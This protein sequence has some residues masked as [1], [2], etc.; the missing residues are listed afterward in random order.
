MRACGNARAK[1]P[2]PHHPGDLDVREV[3]DRARH[4]LDRVQLG[5]AR[6]DDAER[7]T[8]RAALAVRGPAGLGQRGH[9][10]ISSRG[11]HA[12]GR[13]L[14]GAD[15]LDVA[16]A[17]AEVALEARADLRVGG[18][19][20]RLEQARRGH[21][22][23]RGA[24]PALRATLLEE[25]LLDRMERRGARARLDVPS[26]REALDRGDLASL[27]VERQD[28]ARR[29]GPPVH[30]DRAGAAVPRVAGEVGPGEPEVAAKEL[31]ERPGSGHLAAHPAP[32]HRQ[33][34]RVTLVHAHQAPAE[35]P[36]NARRT[37]APTISRRYSAV[38]RTSPIGRAAAVASSATRSTV[39]GT[40]PPATSA[41]SA[42]ATR[43]GVGATAPRASRASVT[44][45]SVAAEREGDADDGDVHGAPHVQALVADVPARVLARNL[46]PREQLARRERGA[47]GTPEEL[48]EGQPPRAGRADDADL[49]I[50]D[51]QHRREIRRGRGVA[52]VAADRGEVSDRGRAHVA[53]GERQHRVLADDDGCSMSA[54]SVVSAPKRIAVGRHVDGAQSGN[55]LQVDHRRRA[56]L[57]L[58]LTEMDHEIRA[59]GQDRRAR[60][61]GQQAAR[62]VE[63]GRTVMRERG[64][65]ASSSAARRGQSSTLHSPGPTARPNRHTTTRRRRS[66][67]IR[68]VGYPSSSRKTGSVCAPSA[69][70]GRGRKGGMP[71]ALMGVPSVGSV[72]SRGCSRSTTISRS[73]TCGSFTDLVHR[74]DRRRRHPL[75]LEPC[76]PLLGGARRENRLE[77]RDQIVTTLDS[78]Q[79]R[80]EA[81]VRGEV[82]PVDRPAESR[83]ELLGEDGDDHVTVACRESL[84][85][86]DRRVARADPARHATVRPE[87][88]G[89]VREQGHLAVQEGQVE[90]RPLAGPLAAEQGA[91]D[92]E[93]AEHPAREVS[94]GKAHPR[95]RPAGLARQA[96]GP[97]HGLE[98]QVERRPFPVR[99]VLAEGRDRADDQPWIEPAQDLGRT[100]EAGHHAR[101]EVLPDDVG[102]ATEIVEDLPPLRRLEVHRDALLVPVDREEVGALALGPQEGRPHH[103]HGIASPRILD[104][105]HLRS[106][107]GEEHR[108]VRAGQHARE[109]ED[110]HAVEQ[111]QRRRAR[112]S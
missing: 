91:G 45:A 10:G 37:R 12:L 110:A 28:E 59:A 75:S 92:R 20:A 78:I 103:A 57:A 88:L 94:H 1:D 77:D 84:V 32:V 18:R 49:R 16:G 7:P 38:A 66:P 22:H 80:I 39:A 109:V 44:R 11:P 90:L 82:R 33:L 70:G 25:S 95:R 112:T 73:R 14:H 43:I 51:E 72:P 61:F 21:D 89:D 104:L 3:L 76:E 2:P 74:V 68:S 67:S 41:A 106:E 69:G 100:A 36:A 97:A 23:A 86:H 4:L 60:L 26:R 29:H 79:V 111:H 30:Q 40:S 105:D 81:R 46:H 47:P 9:A 93:R 6:P 87:V 98:R 42:S 19:R 15:D 53:R 101:T 64:S 52:E 54:V 24:E 96:H 71:V 56:L 58:R 83:P 27:D 108:A 8:G 85:R 35:R 99:P 5:D 55:A 34:Q 63:R 31:E 102:H 13:D 62:L 48:V 107:I 50:E 65:Q 17:P